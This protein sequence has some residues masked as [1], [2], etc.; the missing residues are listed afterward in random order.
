MPFLA[1][2]ISFTLQIIFYKK[3]SERSKSFVCA[4]YGADT[5]FRGYKPK[6]LLNCGLRSPNLACALS[7][8]L[9]TVLCKKF[10]KDQNFLCVH[11][12]EPADARFRGYK[13]KV[14]LNHGFRAPNLACTLSLTV[15]IVFCKKFSER[16]ITFVCAV[17]KA[18]TQF[19]GCKPKAPLNCGLRTPELACTLRLILYCYH[20]KE[21]VMEFARHFELE[22]PPNCYIN[23]WVL[24]WRAHEHCCS[25]RQ[26]QRSSPW[27]GLF[28]W[29]TLGVKFLWPH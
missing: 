8:I 4:V 23:H 28:V 16:S 10:Q 21:H 13:L 3:F 11:S 26:S 18:N 17:Y 12:V 7:L 15:Q 6:A 24:C 19:H 20:S 5:W 27:N 25:T 2:A 1:C 22:R 29:V 14:P 9:W